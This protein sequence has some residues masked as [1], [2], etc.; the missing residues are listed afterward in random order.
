M[1]F[2]IFIAY[3]S[4]VIPLILNYRQN[5]P[6]ENCFHNTAVHNH[7]KLS[8]SFLSRPLSVIIDKRKLF[9]AAF[10]NYLY[11]EKQ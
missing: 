10:E 3:F 11:S 4:L 5:M 6:T 9:S 7:L 8:D 2:R 1:R